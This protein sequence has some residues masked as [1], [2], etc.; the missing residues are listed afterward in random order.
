MKETCFPFP[1]NPPLKKQSQDFLRFLLTS[2]DDH[3][4]CRFSAA[5][6]DFAAIVHH[7]QKERDHAYP[8][9]L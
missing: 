7:N 5:K 9:T 3:V 4:I 8:Q 6:I 2:T 1:V